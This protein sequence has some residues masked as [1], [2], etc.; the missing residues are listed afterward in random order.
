MRLY[1]TGDLGR[2]LSDGCLEYCGRRDWQKKIRGHRIDT[3]EVEMVLL[4]HHAVKEAVVLT[5]E[6]QPDDPRLVAYVVPAGQ[7]APTA[8]DLRQ[9]LLARLADYMIPSVYV[10]LDAL[11]LTANG[12]IDCRALPAPGRKRPPSP[13]PILCRA[14]Q[15]KQP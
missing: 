10:L 15:S 1:R 5:R 6:D 13:P 11:P 4:T 14:L 2:L 12:K 9:H 7:S 3:T 8:S